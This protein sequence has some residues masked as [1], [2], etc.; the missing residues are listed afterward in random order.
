MHISVG[1]ELT[2]EF[3]QP[4]PMIA[5]L[6]VHF[7]GFSDL[8]RPDHLVT[9]PAVPVAGLANEL[10]LVPRPARGKCCIA[11]LNGI[12]GLSRLH[13]GASRMIETSELR[14]ERTGGM[15]RLKVGLPR[16]EQ[17]HAPP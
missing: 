4:T 2:F 3:P 17:H 8:E 11:V 1:C 14:N 7:S 12:H 9:N 13:W 16:W 10:A 15:R 6:N 5:A